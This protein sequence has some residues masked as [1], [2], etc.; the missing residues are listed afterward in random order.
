M[1]RKFVLYG[2]ANQGKSTII[3]HITATACDIDAEKMENY[4]YGKFGSA[5]HPDLLY[6][7]I[8]NKDTTISEN[9][10]D[11]L[12]GETREISR[13]N[14]FS[15]TITTAYR[16]IKF[17]LADEQ[18][19][20]C[21]IDTPGSDRYR[22]QRDRGLY[23]ADVGVFCVEI[24]EV[25]KDSFNEQYIET[26]NVWPLFQRINP[27]A[28]KYPIILLTKMDLHPYEEAYELACQ[29]IYDLCSYSNFN[30]SIIPVSVDVFGRSSVNIFPNGKEFTW[31]HGPTFL[32]KI[33]QL[34]R[35]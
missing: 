12:N 30:T 3:G 18:I 9:G 21:L 33:A 2:E 34:C 11:D 27:R 14:A 26:Q 22:N 23:G 6:S 19:E 16:S 1:S 10:F 28:E 29:K 31:Y 15:K 20:F 32:D 25:L 4:F 5:Y 8:I 35:G 17:K 7:W 13:F 24:G